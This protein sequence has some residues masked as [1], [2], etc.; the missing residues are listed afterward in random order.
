MCSF[1][2]LKC[3]P[4]L[5]SPTRTLGMHD[6]KMYAI[7]TVGVDVCIPVT[8][9]RIE[10]HN[11]FFCVCCPYKAIPHPSDAWLVQENHTQNGMTNLYII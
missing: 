9:F 5:P 8:S 11:T 6:T 7:N 10:A 4:P 1:L 2:I 3:P